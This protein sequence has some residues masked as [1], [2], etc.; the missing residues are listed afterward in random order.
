ML[1]IPMIYIVR[2]SKKKGSLVGTPSYKDYSTLVSMLGCP[3][4]VVS[5]NRRQKN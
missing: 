5:W 3:D 2:A 1:R 4:L